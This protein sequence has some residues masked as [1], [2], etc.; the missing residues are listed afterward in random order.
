MLPFPWK[1]SWCPLLLLLLSGRSDQIRVFCR[2][3][4]SAAL[5]FFSWLKT[6]RS[7]GWNIQ[8]ISICSLTVKREAFVYFKNGNESLPVQD[9][10]LCLQPGSLWFPFIK[11][12]F[13]VCGDNFANLHVNSSL[14]NRIV[15]SHKLCSIRK[16]C[17]DL[18]FTKRVCYAFHHIIFCKNR[19]SKL[20]QLYN[21]FAITGQFRSSELI[22]ASAST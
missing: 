14:L 2:P 19:G 12:D 18:H 20:H 1:P 16:C 17:L 8:M 15:Y 7:T 4:R 22:Y 11:Y 5:L 6:D 10:R 21:S 9:D 3:S 13:S